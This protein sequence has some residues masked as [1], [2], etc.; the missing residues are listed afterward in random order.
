MTF[1]AFCF[2]HLLITDRF[3]AYQCGL[4]DPRELFHVLVSDSGLRSYWFSF[5]TLSLRCARK[6]SAYTNQF[7]YYYFTP[8]GLFPPAFSVGF[9]L[10]FERQKSPQLFRTLLSV[11]ANLSYVAVWMV[12]SYFHVFHSLNQ[13]FRDCSKCTNYNWYH[14]HLHVP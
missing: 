14:R 3:T 12:S 4:R 11:L 8:S 7:A 6:S 1:L 13:F 2:Q 10:K 9:S 5:M